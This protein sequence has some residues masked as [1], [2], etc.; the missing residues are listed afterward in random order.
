MGSN[1]K[2]VV[3][4]DSVYY[5]VVSQDDA[6]A[7]AA[8]TPAY[9]APIMTISQAPATSQK[10]QY[11]DNQPFDVMTGEGETKLDLEVTGVSLETL[12]TLL[13]KVFDGD[14]DRLFDNGGTPPD[15]ALGFRSKKSDGEYR[16]FWF[17]KGKFSAPSEE[18]ATQTDTPDPKSTKLVFTAVRTIYQFDLGSIN[19]SVKR[20]AGDTNDTDFS[21]TG[22]FTTV[23]V[24]VAG[25]P[26]ALT[27]TPSPVDGAISQAADVTITLT[28]NNVLTGGAEYGIGLLK[29]STEAAVSV[30]RSINAARKIVTLAHADLDASTTYLIT[31]NGVR[32]VFGQSLADVVYDFDTAA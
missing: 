17:L 8:G 29:A 12:A 3:G 14:T 32:D 11:A 28:F 20:V 31:V 24:P 16:Y 18:F 21:E 4:V 9:L 27:C 10:T 26:D 6:S 5:A 25:S 7:Y 19:D 1:Y 30:T 15:V 13:G 2:S 22:W 23:Q